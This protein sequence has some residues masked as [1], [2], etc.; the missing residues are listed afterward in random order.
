MLALVALLLMVIPAGAAQTSPA[1]KTA[2]NAAA[3]LARGWGALA[4]GDLKT[5]ASAAQKALADSPR[6]A[7]A[8]AL[9]VEVEIARGGSAAG[10]DAY[11]RWLGAKRVEAAHV[12]R[13]VATAYLQDAVRQKEAGA[14]RVEALKA[15]VADGDPDA[16]ASLAAAGPTGVLEARLLASLGDETAVRT[17]IAQLQSLPDKRGTID[18]LVESRSPLAFAP[19]VEMLSDARDENRAAAADGLGRL[20]A[21]DAIDR[22][23]PLLQDPSFPVRMTAAK[24]LYRLGDDG[25]AQLLEQLLASEHASVRMGA[26]EALSVR[27]GGNWQSVARALADDPDETVQLQ[28]ARLMAPYDRE[29]AQ[30]VLERLQRSENPAVREEAGRIFT[31]R[32]AHDFASLRGLLRSPD[33]VTATR[34]ASRILELTR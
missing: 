5:A 21:R 28:A 1:Q 2:G 31:E 23:T 27:P 14:S 15:L 22:I 4:E 32:V 26:A 16:R 34:A 18:A 7:A 24:A 10:L 17:L 12:L 3:V 33:R 11:E 19:L 29:L 6:S 30:R 9:A 8:V 13:R 25:G 20:G